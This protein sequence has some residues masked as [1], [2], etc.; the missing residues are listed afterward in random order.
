LGT[1]RLLFPSPRASISTL[2]VGHLKTPS[3]RRD[4]RAWLAL[5]RK[6][7]VGGVAGATVYCLGICLTYHLSAPRTH[8]NAFSV[9]TGAAT[10][11]LDGIRRVSDQCAAKPYTTTFFLCDRYKLAPFVA[12]NLLAT[13]LACQTSP[14]R[15]SAP[16]PAAAWCQHHYTLLHRASAGY[17]RITSLYLA[18]PS[19]NVVT[20]NSRTATL[21]FNV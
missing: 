2:S 19:S 17:R 20:T 6:T 14:L 16:A 5:T 9:T 15:A 13:G 10:W 12:T 8:A 18:T 21:P 7:L 3:R 1:P 4:R 11:L